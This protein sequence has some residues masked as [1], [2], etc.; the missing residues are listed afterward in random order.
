MPVPAFGPLITGQ[1]LEVL[2]QGTLNQ[3]ATL[4]YNTF[5]FRVQAIDDQQPI[6]EKTKRDFLVLFVLAW[7]AQM[8][9]LVG[10]NYVRMRTLLH[11]ITSVTGR[12][13]HPTQPEIHYSEAIEVVDDP[14]RPGGVQT[15]SAPDF[16]AVEFKTATG[17]VARNWR[18]GFHVGA[19]PQASILGQRLT[20]N[21]VAAYGAAAT[22][23]VATYQLAGDNARLIPV[24]FSGQRAIGQNLGQ[25]Y[26]QA[27]NFS[28]DITT[29]TPV[30][31]L[32]S[33][34][35]RKL[36]PAN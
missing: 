29:T 20:D 21:A 17:F 4:C 10:N 12:V 35:H 27:F 22:Q 19:I 31:I 30:Q 32:G 2:I 28:R 6:P 26:S 11:C 7:Q 23:L 13:G 24:K 25:D 8:M 5:K 16:V 33:M 34:L 18:G 15:P 14:P 1:V 36:R 3:G 9:P